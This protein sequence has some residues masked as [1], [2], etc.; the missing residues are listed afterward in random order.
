VVAI[1]AATI[2]VTAAG[3]SEKPKTWKR[4]PPPPRWLGRPIGVLVL[5]LF[6]PVTKL[7]PQWWPRFVGRTLTKF[8]SEFPRSFEPSER[9]VLVCAYYKSGTNWTMQIAVQIAHRG[10]AEFGHIHD[11]VPWPDMSPRAGYAVPLDVD[12]PQRCAPTH[13]R[14]IKTH[15]ALDDLPYSPAA[16]Y[17]CV[18]R[19]PKD[20]FVSSYH[21]TR[22]L[23][24]G[25]LMPSVD[26]WL[27]AFLS[28]DAPIG[29]WARHLASG[30]RLRERVNVLFLTY[31]GMRADL[32]SA[33]DTIAAFMGVT[34]TAGERAA[35]IERSSFDYMKRIEHAFEAPGAPWANAKGAMM[36]RGESGSSGELIT[37]EQQR[38][39]DDHWRAELRRLGCDFPYDDV[40]NAPKPAARRASAQR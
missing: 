8:L 9:D 26:A 6:W 34:L 2:A 7:F 38:R 4:T 32:S 17:I 36:R 3:M 35:V 29:S 5:G 18:V 13:L 12:E 27:D 40:F 31:D 37:P 16:R 23:V 30:W 28:A 21:F 19:D 1:S 25:S 10:R 39:I 24:L 15:L 20:V 11:L 33:V 22:A 14:I